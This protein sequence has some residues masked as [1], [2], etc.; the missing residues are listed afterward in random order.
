[1]L[2]FCFRI[3]KEPLYMIEVQLSIIPDAVI[4]HVT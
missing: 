4:E 2:N 1:M 3:Q